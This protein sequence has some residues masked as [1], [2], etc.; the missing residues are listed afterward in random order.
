MKTSFKPVPL[1]L[2]LSTLPAAR[3]QPV[4]PK[5]LPSAAVLI[6]VPLQGGT[7]WGSGLYM[8]LSNTVFLVTADHVL[9]DPLAS[10]TLSL[11]D[12]T[13][14]DALAAKFVQPEADDSVSQYLTNQLSSETRQLLVGFDRGANFQLKVN[15]AEHLV[16]D[17]NGVLSTGLYDSLRF[18]NVALSP[19]ISILR[20]Q[21]PQGADLVRF[22][23]ML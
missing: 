1:L 16:K 3:A 4:V 7:G 23:R 5:D 18:T 12:L 15:L 20:E 2:L 11:S 19:Q 6:E 8:R 21:H 13:D 10:P 14:I 22:N 17:L 9:F